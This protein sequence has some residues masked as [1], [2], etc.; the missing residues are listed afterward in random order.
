MGKGV[1]SDFVGRLSIAAKRGCYGE[2]P[3]EPALS[4]PKWARLRDLS[5]SRVFIS[6]I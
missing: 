3:Q 6:A 1:R 2:R 4:L 5:I